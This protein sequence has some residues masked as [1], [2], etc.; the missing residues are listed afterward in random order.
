MAIYRAHNSSS[1]NPGACF[2]LAAYKKKAAKAPTPARAPPTWRLLAAPVKYGGGG[3]YFPVPDGLAV[4][5]GTVGTP[6][7]V[8]MIGYGAEPVG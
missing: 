4:P 5:E 2:Q 7:P 3:V 8:G 6:V 1:L